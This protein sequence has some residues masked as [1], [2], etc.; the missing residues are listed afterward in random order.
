[1]TDYRYDPYDYNMNNS[2]NTNT[3]TYDDTEDKEETN[4]N[5][6][7]NYDYEYDPDNIGRVYHTFKSV[8]N[9][10]GTV[11]TH[12]NQLQPKK[13]VIPPAEINDI[14]TQSE[15]KGI[16][17]TKFKKAD[18]RKELLNSLLHSK[19]EPA[20]YWSAELICAGHFEELWD[21][22]I[23]FYSKHI[24]SGNPKLAVYLDKKVERFK[25]TIHG[26]YSGYEIKMR[27][28]DRIRHMFCEIMC[29]L[30][31]AKR[32]HTFDTVKIK[33]EYF[34]ISTLSDKL[35]APSVRYS[36]LVFKNGEDP[37]E[38]FIAVNELVYNL[39]V[40]NLMEICFW[41][42]WI[43]E[44]DN[45]MRSRKQMLKC[46]RRSFVPV[47]SKLQMDVVWILWDIFFKVCDENVH[48]KN[49]RLIKSIINSLLRLFCVRFTTGC[50]R[51]RK[52]ILYFVASILVEGVNVNE[53]IIRSSEKDKMTSIISKINLVY[54]QLKKNEESPATDYL[55]TNVKSSNL[56]KT[57]EQ[58]E[59]LNSLGESFIPRIE[60]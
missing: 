57:I 43:I 49:G 47:D 10:D 46:S 51:K 42:E 15:F 35:K 21:I 20:C 17:F 37:K 1:M 52:S 41:I 36:E 7:S 2:N 60:E 45:F 6:N 34:D 12:Q 33:H 50:V 55:F 54:G 19:I 59:Q 8:K 14:R 40:D 24:H 11:H 18:V 38:L 58:L 32:K 23:Y 44:Y 27:N 25:D 5:N 13:L 31:D 28:N 4:T 39:T 26:G 56:E 48:L 53:E 22:I 29:I 3:N 9:I 30:C 16:T